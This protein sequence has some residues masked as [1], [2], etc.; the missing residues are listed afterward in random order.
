MKNQVVKSSRNKFAID[1]T[2]DKVEKLY[3]PTSTITYS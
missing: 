3:I 1:I 2:Y